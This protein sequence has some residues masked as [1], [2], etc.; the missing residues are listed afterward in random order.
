[1]RYVYIFLIGVAMVFI[2]LFVFQ[3]PSLTTISLFSASITLPL[4]IIILLTYS[5]GILTGGGVVSLLRS[6]IQGA[7]KKQKRE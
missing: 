3:N 1:M 4:S 2:L 6:L 5:L 7:S